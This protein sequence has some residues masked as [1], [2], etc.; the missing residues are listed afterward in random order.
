MNIIEA[1]KSGKPFKRREWSA[2]Q[3]PELLA[4]KE[5]RFGTEDFLADD[6]EIEGKEVPVTLSK[7]AHAYADIMKRNAFKR[8]WDMGSDKNPTINEL[9]K[10]LGLIE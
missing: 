9:A 3:I 8:D 4:S 1:V 5:L 6:W 7:L 2:Y 10:E